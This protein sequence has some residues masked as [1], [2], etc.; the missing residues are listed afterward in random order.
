MRLSQSCTVKLKPSGSNR[1]LSVGVAVIPLL[2]M[3]P[4]FRP[5]IGP[6]VWVLVSASVCSFALLLLLLRLNSAT[7]YTLTL[8]ANGDLTLVDRH[9]NI[10]KGQLGSGAVVSRLGVMVAIYRQPGRQK[11]W[12]WL[13]HDAMS[14]SEYRQLCRYLNYR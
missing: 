12:L 2:L 11:S 5:F 7:S 10:A 3:L 1:Y 13:A 4:L 6:P 14:E 9:Q 8:Y